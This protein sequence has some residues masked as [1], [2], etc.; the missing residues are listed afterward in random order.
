MEMCPEMRE[1][2]RGRMMCVEKGD[3]HGEGP[4]DSLA[5]RRVRV[6]ERLGKRLGPHLL[7]RERVL[8]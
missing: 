1:V 6:V 2:C 4:A 7:R 5:D 3:V 8:Y